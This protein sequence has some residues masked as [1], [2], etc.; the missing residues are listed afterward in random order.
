MRRRKFTLIELLVVI[1]II[2]VLAGM[3]LPA[4]GTARGRVYS[5]SC[6]NNLKNIGLA[7]AAYTND[8]SDWILPAA[9]TKAN[10]AADNFQ[11][12]WWGTLGGLGGKANYGITL[13]VEDGVIKAGGTLDCPSERVSFGSPVDKQFK[14][15]K[16]I[17]GAIGAQAIAAGDTP[18]HNKNDIR[19]TNCLVYPSKV[20]FAAD[21]FATHCY[22]SVQTSN[23]TEF[24][25]RHGAGEISRGTDSVS[26]LGRGKTS[27]LYIDGHSE[28]RNA[29]S[30]ITD[31][32]NAS[33]QKAGA[34]TSSSIETCG[35]D[36]TKGV[37]LYE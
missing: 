19:K 13:E 4:L 31:S 25:F 3:L 20:I 6:L 10:W 37:T 33:A 36:R 15:A 7:Q 16:Y 30:L 17:M 22:N 32:P 24:S 23:I 29:E 12:S 2:A 14:Q 28:E 18:N 11:A 21:S 5:I 34:I 26:L 1:A 35:Y 9:Q 27:V 8:F